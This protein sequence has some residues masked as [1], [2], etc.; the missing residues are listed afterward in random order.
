MEHSVLGNALQ[1]KAM[2]DASRNTEGRNSNWPQLPK[3][4]FY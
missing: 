1:F 4:I 3:E 2:S